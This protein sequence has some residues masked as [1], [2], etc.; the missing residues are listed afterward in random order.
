VSTSPQF[1]LGPAS[2]LP[3]GGIEREEDL[4]LAAVWAGLVRNRWL[5]L[6][7]VAL[8]LGGAVVY[9]LRQTPTYEATATLRIQE[10]QLDISQ[11]Y[12]TLSTGVAGSDLGT[13]IAVLG[14]RALR[15][16][17]VRALGLQLQVLEPQRFAREKLIGRIK[18]APDAQP[19][20]FRLVSRADG[21]FDI[22][23]VD[24]TSQAR[25][26]G[27]DGF[28]QLPGVSFALTPKATEFEE[29]LI[30]IQ[31][32]A[33]AVDGLAGGLSV[34][35]PRND[36]YI[37]TVTYSSTDRLLAR[38]VPNLITASYIARRQL[39]RTSEARSTVKFLREQLAR[40][41]GELAASEESFRSFQERAHV[42]DPQVEISHEVAR[43][44]QKE[45]ERSSIQ[46]ER[47][48]LRESLAEIEGAAAREP[49]GPSPYR[50]LTG[51]PFILRNPAASTLLTAL[52]TA[53]NDRAA[54]VGATAKDP[55]VVI[56]NARIRDLENQ[57]HA[58]ATRYLAGLGSEV[59]SFDTAL[60]KFQRELDAIPGKQLEH[61]RLAR[62][63]KALDEVHTLLQQKLKEAEIAEAA[64]DASVQVIDAATAPNE[65]SSPNPKFNG[66]VAL[67]VGLLLGLAATLIRELRDKSVHTRKDI[68][69][70]TGVPVLALIPRMFSRNGRVALITEKL[71]IKPANSARRKESS[72]GGAY[73]FL[74][75]GQPGA[76]GQG[77]GSSSELPAH[78]SPTVRLAMSHSGQMV[79]ESYGLLQTNLAFAHTVSPVNAIVIT[80]PLAEDGKTTC[81][82]NLAITLAL[83]GSRTLLVDADLR[84][85]LIH[86]AFETNRAPGLS[87]LLSR[88]GA[89]SE[90][91]RSVK[92]GDEGAEL[93]YLTS[94]ALPANPSGLLENSF[95]AFLATVRERFDFVIIDSPPVNIISDASLLG[96][97]AD[98]V[99]LVARSGFTQSASLAYATEQ[100]NRVGVRIL[101]VVLNDIDFKREAGYDASYRYYTASHSTSGSRTS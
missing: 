49:S 99:V 81:A 76:D 52:I 95:Q 80:S 11:I 43:L 3:S 70:A 83:R 96:R 84:R 87:E 79:A 9:T 28:V 25:T 100:L 1:V 35:K 41:Q 48:A 27:S 94:G 73:T 31:S 45:S 90:V 62:K 10:R 19:A 88:S 98:G 17:A 92:V 47:D 51:L 75:A 2:G 53:E 44:I 7:C 8:V 4:S 12:R 77:P 26:S 68:A 22:L 6:G 82:T 91:I 85:G 56:L 33:S 69:V 36:A 20:Q 32:F 24:D 29:L 15:E 61:A 50:R 60:G 74:G 54:R 40:V 78:A 89:V 18:V 64:Q 72:R 23:G 42:L 57:L 86:A 58:I 39:N 55:D 21:R 63:V 13:E 67:A 97:L 46:A 65:P 30:G 101:G 16:D 59:A 14:S 38:D 71:R 66:L 93:K 37:L 5:I 34:D